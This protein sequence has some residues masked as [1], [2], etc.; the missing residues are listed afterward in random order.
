MTIEPKCMSWKRLYEEVA[1]AN[2]LLHDV[3][4]RLSAST[5]DKVQLA[6]DLERLT[7]RSYAALEALSDARRAVSSEP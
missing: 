4:S 7:R 5:E 6:H 2:L 3:K 1:R